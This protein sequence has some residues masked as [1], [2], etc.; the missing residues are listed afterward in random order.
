M[1][2]ADCPTVA[3]HQYTATYLPVLTSATFAS[4][5]DLTLTVKADSAV[6]G[7]TYSFAFADEGITGACSTTPSDFHAGTNWNPTLDGACAEVHSFTFHW[8]ELSAV[9]S[10]SQKS[11]C[12][13]SVYEVENVVIFNATLMVTQHDVLQQIRGQDV[14]RSTTSP[15]SLSISFPKYGVVNT[16]ELTIFAP[17]DVRAAI[18]QQSYDV[19][20]HEG[21]FRLFTSVQYPFALDNIVMLESG[22]NGIIIT[23]SVAVNQESYTCPPANSAC[24][25]LYDLVIT[26]DICR[27]SGQFK[28]KFD[29]ICRTTDNC[30]L[31]GTETVELTWTT[32]SSNLCGVTNGSASLDISLNT[33]LSGF[34]TERKGFLI[35]QTIY[36]QAAAESDEVLVEKIFIK[37][38]SIFYED[39]SAPNPAERLILTDGTV[40]SMATSPSPLYV[41]SVG[42][43]PSRQAT[44]IVDPSL[45]TIQ[46]DG[47]VTVSI[48][49]F[50]G[51]QFKNVAYT[52]RVVIG[53]GQ[54]QKLKR[55]VTPSFSTSG[56]SSTQ[57]VV[58]NQNLE[59]NTQYG[60]QQPTSSA[61]LSQP[62]ALFAVILISAIVLLL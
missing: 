38:C 35:G 62:I 37:N 40:S 10:T 46:P 4:Q 36:L 51:V 55:G 58:G 19:L 15:L 27:I 57:I 61:A 43:A 49:C 48:G 26:G 42:P 30:P 22:N 23:P 6:V 12:G 50:I 60:T 7:R 5:N 52:K 3:P 25:K 24:N 34:S 28:V 39:G 45:F 18:S 32:D 9:G 11:K 14:L 17:I 41:A 54:L 56:Y 2:Y 20:E 8:S 53:G 31:L 59:S 13:F 44:I 47:N 16:S 33:Y 29:I 21:L 1:I